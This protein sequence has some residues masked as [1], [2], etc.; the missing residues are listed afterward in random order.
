V[1]TTIRSLPQF[2]DVQLNWS[3]TKK[4]SLKRTK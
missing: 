3:V 2:E 1:T 4:I